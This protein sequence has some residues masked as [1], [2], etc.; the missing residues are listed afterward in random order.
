MN[1][2][3]SQLQRACVKWFDLQYPVYKQLLFA[4]PNGGKRNVLEASIMQA[5]GV[6]AGVADMFFSIAKHRLFKGSV[7][8]YGLYIEFKIG[9]NKQSAHQV[10]FQNFVEDERYK[11]III[12]SFD[13]FKALIESYLKIE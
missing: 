7:D 12:R 1:H 11:Y 3:E 5:E 6:R 13:E 4:I 10:L 2:K 8:Y 9:N